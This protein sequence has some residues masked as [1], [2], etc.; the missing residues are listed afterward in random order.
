[1]TPGNSISPVVVTPLY[2][3][4]LKP[5][6]EVSLGVLRKVLKAHPRVFVSPEDLEIPETFL[7]G[8]TVERFP[9]WHFRIYPEGYNRLLMSAD[10]FRRF[11]RF[12]HMLVYQMDCLVFRDDLHEWCANGWD[13]VGSP[14]CDDFPAGAVV[15]W[16][17]GNGGFSLRRISTAVRILSKR[18]PRGTAY[19]I[20][21]VHYAEKSAREW[22][23]TNLRKKIRQWTGLWNVEDELANYPENEDRF[24]SV[25]A[26]RFDASYSKPA[27]EEALRFGVEKNPRQ[28]VAQSGVLPFGCHGWGTYD[29][30]FWWEILRREN[31]A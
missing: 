1:M 27:P 25:E 21:P 12:S 6:E 15:S 4:P 28:T 20:Q 24:W 13:Y 23:V 9:S 30:S 16:K 19:P 26:E 10:F 17:V 2:R 18:I 31:L 11:H 22:L 8:E 7:A 14:W 29:K 3:F 5:E